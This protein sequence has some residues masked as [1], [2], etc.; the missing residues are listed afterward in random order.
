[1]E[2]VGVAGD[3]RH[4]SLLAS[5]PLLLYLP[6]AQNYDGR[7]VVMIRTAVDPLALL[8]PVR[9]EVAALDKNLP[10]AY[11]ETLSDHIAQSLWQQRMAARLIG[12]FGA[13]AL[14]LAAIGLYGVISRS[15]AQRT[16]EI[17]VRM[18]LG[19]NR[20]EILKLVVGQG[21]KLTLVGVAL[22]LTA[23]VLS[24]YK[25]T[26]FLYGVN[27]Y[28]PASLAFACLVLAGVALLASYMPARQATKVDPMVALRYE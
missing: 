5:P 8:R 17:G 27:A 6:R 13:L 15:V 25:L 7:G 11:S 4:R 3:T 12:L 21:V 16:R 20:A 18:A 26:G 10:I 24:T 22:G 28:D 19:A 9:A 2:I 14:T 1:V 23:A